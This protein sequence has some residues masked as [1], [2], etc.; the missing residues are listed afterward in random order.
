MSYCLALRAFLGL[1]V[2]VLL[3]GA[4]AGGL[5]GGVAGHGERPRSSL[6]LKLADAENV[7][8]LAVNGLAVNGA[9]RALYNSVKKCLHSI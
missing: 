5:P 3:E 1:D 4:P 8:I 6:L 2:T 9:L 7:L